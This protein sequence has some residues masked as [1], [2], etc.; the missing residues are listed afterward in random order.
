M[1]ASADAEIGSPP[2]EGSTTVQEWELLSASALLAQGHGLGFGLPPL[3]TPSLHTSLVVD[4][5]ASRRNLDSERELGFL[6]RN[7]DNSSLP[8]DVSHIAVVS[9]SSSSTIEPFT[10]GWKPQFR[11]AGAV[12]QEDYYV[13]DPLPAFTSNANIAPEPFLNLDERFVS[14]SA[15]STVNKSRRQ[16]SPKKTKG[17][18]L[19]D[20]RGRPIENMFSMKKQEN[21]TEN[22]DVDDQDAEIGF[23]V[24]DCDDLNKGSVIGTF[25]PQNIQAWRKKLPF[26][27]RK[28]YIFWSIAFGTVFL[29]V[30]IIRYRS[31]RE[32]MDLS[33]EVHLEDK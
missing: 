28:S 11:I 1:A 8:L 24:A 7:G 19:Q 33:H 26:S 2:D 6:F 20:S 5:G 16:P 17:P 29:G 25:S 22:V 9:N 21:S 10:E 23:S 30:F 4:D 3:A 12:M 32:H 18:P 15:K 13:P 31:Q 14:E 27:R